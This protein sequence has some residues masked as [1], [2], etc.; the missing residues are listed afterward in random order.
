MNKEEYNKNP[1]LC[2]QCGKP[3]TYQQFTYNQKFCCHKCSNQNKETRPPRSEESRRK[4]SESIKNYYKRFPSTNIYFIHCISC[5]KLFVSKC[6]NKKTCCEKCRR[7]IISLAN[8]NK[9]HD[10]IKYKS[11]SKKGLYKNIP[12]DSSWE[13]A[14]LIYCLDHNINIKR[15]KNRFKYQIDGKTHFYYPDFII[16]NDTYIEIKGRKDKTVEYKNNCI[17]TLNLNFQMIDS[18]KIG[19]YIR[20]VKNNYKVKNIWDLY[21]VK[22]FN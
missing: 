12:C 17:K 5:G 11:W 21:D 13:L 2:L 16:D 7:N 20:Y 19:K 10:S 18:D 4:T 15:N 6:K 14:F 1:K 8:K 22:Y 3:L 9:I